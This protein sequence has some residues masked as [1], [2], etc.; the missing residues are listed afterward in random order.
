MTLIK[1]NAN[2]VRVTRLNKPLLFL[3]DLFYTIA[4]AELWKM[5]VFLFILQACLIVGLMSITAAAPDLCDFVNYKASD[6][7][8]ILSAKAVIFGSLEGT[9]ELSCSVFKLCFTILKIFIDSAVGIFLY[10]RLKTGRKRYHTFRASSNLHLLIKD[11]QLCIEALFVDMRE[12]QLVGT[13]FSCFY[14][15]DQYQVKPLKTESSGHLLTGLRVRHV[16]DETSPMFHMVSPI[17]SLGQFSDS[18]RGEIVYAIS[19]EDL[20]SGLTDF[21]RSYT[22][23]RTFDFPNMWS[24]DYRGTS[25]DYS[26]LSS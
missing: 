20:R 26:M 16:I 15:N 12:F 4:T 24:S 10:S 9:E 13:S 6:A 22:S 25:V 14:I 7:R 17:D 18:F 19:G 2:R 3:L 1:A 5:L 11:A 21:R 8:F 23:F